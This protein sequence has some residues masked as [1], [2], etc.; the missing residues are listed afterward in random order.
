MGPITVVFADGSFLVREAVAHVLAEADDVELMAVCRDRAAL[1]AAVERV[2]PSVAVVG[3]DLPPASGRPPIV[4][5][6]RLRHPG[7]GIVELSDRSDPR[8]NVELL[9]D[10]SGGRAYLLKEQLDGSRQL[11]A[12]IDL[13]ARGGAYFEACVIERMRATRRRADSSPLTELSPREREVLA[14]IATGRSNACIASDLELTKRAI[15]KHINAIFLKLGLSCE[16][17]VSRRVK[18]ALIHQAATRE[19]P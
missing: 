18:A 15:E 1:L 9:T 14:Q 5:E 11:L 8:L 3:T 4:E 12:A 6:L 13:V 19:E 7:A 10:G 2:R 17:D 16:P